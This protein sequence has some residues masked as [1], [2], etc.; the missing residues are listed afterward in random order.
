MMHKEHFSHIP[1]SV[2]SLSLTS[3]HSLMCELHLH[4]YM[5][6]HR[7][8]EKHLVPDRQEE[9]LF[10][11]S[12]CFREGWK[13]ERNGQEWERELEGWE[14]C[15]RWVISV[16]GIGKGR[17]AVVARVHPN[18]CWKQTGSQGVK[19]VARIHIRRI[20]EDGAEEQNG[21]R[22]LTLCRPCHY[23]LVSHVYYTL[24]TCFPCSLLDQCTW[25]DFI[26]RSF[27]ID[28]VVSPLCRLKRGCFGIGCFHPVL[29]F[30]CLGGLVMY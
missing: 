3:Y 28:R 5:L 8:Y 1:I 27:M 19:A 13:H 24:Y 22:Y 21:Q 7:G 14:Q 18:L 9:L 20:G 17:V 2:L 16:W 6:L 12:I 15:Q 29:P 30:L 23:P 11:Q 4:L 10:I 26:N 25:K